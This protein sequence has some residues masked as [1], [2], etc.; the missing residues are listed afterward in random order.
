MIGNPWGKNFLVGYLID[1]LRKVFDRIEDPRNGNNKQY[2]FSDIAMSAFSAFFIQS[3]SFLEHQR[4]FHKIHGKNAVG[5]LFGVERLPT[6]NHIRKQLDRI[7][8][9]AV[10][11]GFDLALTVLKQHRA[12]TPFRVLGGHTLIALDGSEFHNSRKV[13]CDQCQWRVKN[14]HQDDQYTEYYHSVLAAVMIGP[15]HPYAVP[16]RPEFILPQDG[17][18][19]Q[20]CET[21]AAYRWF[22]NNAAHYADLS[23]LY[24][25][26]DLYAKQPMCETVIA[27]GA[28]FIFRVKTGDHKTLFSYI[29]GIDWPSKTHIVKTPGRNQP[30]KQYTYRWTYC[31]VP[32]TANKDALE[33]YYVDLH[34]RDVGAKDKVRSFRYITSVVPNENNVEQIVACGRTRWKIENEAFNLL[35]NQ[36]Y[37]V[38]HNFGHGDEGLSN[39]LLSLN[40]I[41]F[42]FHGACDQVCALWKKARQECFRR[43]R[44]FATLDLL[45]EYMY[46]ENWRELLIMIAYPEQR[47]IAKMRA[48]P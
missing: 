29:D 48:P 32:L 18:K 7:D 31:E 35:K 37:H 34:I 25:G 2:S 8:C 40:L 30:N 4:I 15:G 9:N 13:H 17:D 26:D 14:K 46:F 11:E 19:K 27:A 22:A 12:L 10:F 36:G 23:P 16:L 1:S 28:Q 39:T 44:F 6:D 3:S 47:P 20:D 24:L 38:E 5:S 43:T 45:T 41:A 42:A 33:V 21:K